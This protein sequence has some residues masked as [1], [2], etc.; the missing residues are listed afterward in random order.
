MHVSLI[1]VLCLSTYIMSAFMYIF[2]HLDYHPQHHYYHQVA[3]LL[4]YE[5]NIMHMLILIM[6]KNQRTF[7]NIT[8]TSISLIIIIVICQLVLSY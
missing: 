8:I 2:L 1:P 6:Y 3:A 7:F 5:H 4:Y